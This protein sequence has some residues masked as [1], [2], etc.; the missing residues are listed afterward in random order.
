MAGHGLAGVNVHLSREKP[1]QLLERGSHSGD[2]KYMC[3]YGAG[4]SWELCKFAFPKA[5]S[6]STSFKVCESMLHNEKLS[7]H[8]KRS[9]QH[10]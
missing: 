6:V 1:A 9:I 3:D 5:P 4:R 8:R 2:G 10:R 7:Q